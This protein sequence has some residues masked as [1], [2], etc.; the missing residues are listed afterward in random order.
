MKK[1]FWMLLA[2]SIFAGALE[3][4]GN[5]SR[6]KRAQ[7]EE[8]N[9]D[10]CM[11]NLKSF[12]A[13]LKLYAATNNGVMPGKNN[14]AGLQML[15]K[16]GITSKE[17]SC[18]AYRGKKLREKNTLSEAFSPYIYFGGINLAQAIKKCP[19]LVIMCD[20]PGSRHVTVL[21]AD[22]SVERLDAK[23]YKIDISNVQ[24]IVT[25]L[26]TI[27]KYPASELKSLQTKAKAMDKSLAYSTR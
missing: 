18:K 8:K 25:L 13:S 26:N 14:F 5:T 3:L 20:K 6:R 15:L 23:K 7:L 16:H 1:I 22:G 4:Q 19:K 24:S 2:V 17:F 9:K 21:L 11:S 27:Y 12:Y 10:L